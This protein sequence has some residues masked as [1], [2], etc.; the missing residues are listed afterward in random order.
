MNIIIG[1]PPK[2]SNNTLVSIDLEIFEA[3]K[4]ILHRPHTGRFACLSICSNDDP[5]TVYIIDKET[6][7]PHALDRIK[8]SIWVAHNLKFDVTH[9]R[10]WANIP[11]RKKAICT[12]I[13][14]RIMWGGYYDNFGLD[15]LVRRY[16]DI[17]LD[18]SL[19]K[20]FET[21]TEMT[22]ELIEYAALDA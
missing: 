22:P 4:K 5:E 20:T 11:P 21:A 12:M 10:R 19:Q 18:K 1:D 17:K 9:L 15:H 14:E 6:S 16:L 7:V 13:L 3:N 2:I 8:N